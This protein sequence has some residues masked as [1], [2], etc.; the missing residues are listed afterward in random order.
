MRVYFFDTSSLTPR[1]FKGAYTAKV[2][3][4]LATPNSEFYICEFSIIEMSSALAQQYRIHTLPIADFHSMRGQFE[5]DIASGLLRVR[6]VGANDLRNAR[7]LLE[8]AAVVN[9]RNLRSAD[10]V[11]AACCRDLAHEL[12]R[13]VIFYTRDWTQYSSIYDIQSYRSALKLRFLGKGRGGMPP[14][15]G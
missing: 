12:G 6:G 10:A 5:N 2:D 8:D 11:I 9:K 3:R 4:I 15:T 1:Y 7:D 14:R 13:R